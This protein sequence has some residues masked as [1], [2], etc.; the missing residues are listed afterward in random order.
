M[1]LHAA[2]QLEQTGQH[3]VDVPEILQVPPLLAPDINAGMLIK[4]YILITGCQ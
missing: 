2:R 4:C 3:S 1:A